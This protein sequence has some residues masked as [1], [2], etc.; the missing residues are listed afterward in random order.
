MKRDLVARLAELGYHEHDGVLIQELPDGSARQFR[1]EPDKVNLHTRLVPAR[2]TDD[3]QSDL[4]WESSGGILRQWKTDR[5][6][7]MLEWLLD[8]GMKI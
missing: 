4:P 1:L 8:Q 6:T 2:R 7:A 3:I 5:N